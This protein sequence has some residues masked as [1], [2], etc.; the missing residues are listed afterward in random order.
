[1]FLNDAINQHSSADPTVSHSIPQ[2]PALWTWLVKNM[3]L[4]K[5][6][7]CMS[8]CEV[9]TWVPSQCELSLGICY[10]SHSELILATEFTWYVT[11]L[12]NLDY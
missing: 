12:F 5:L 2:Q 6:I 9:T 8:L 3:K 1:M 4:L 10:I 7:N 11:N